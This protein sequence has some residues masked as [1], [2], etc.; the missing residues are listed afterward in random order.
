MLGHI[1]MG[2]R[3][4]H[5]TNQFLAFNKPPGIA[6]QSR[7]D[8]DFYQLANGYA[9]RKLYVVHRIDQPASGIVLFARSKTSAGLISAGFAESKFRRVYH[10]V[11]SRKPNVTEGTIHHWL[12]HN[13][14]TNKSEIA[15][16]PKVG[17]KPCKLRFQF[18][19]SSD[20]WH[21]LK[22][23]IQTGRH[24][25]IRAQLSAEGMHIKGDVKYGARRPNRDRSIH[26]HASE[27]DMI[28]PVN[29][30]RVTI[31]ASWPNE[32]LWNF[33]KGSLDSS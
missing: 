33:F 6:V 10:T 22:V 4:C 17:F 21:L 13:P 28:H 31:K 7:E 15:Q 12:K 26:L 11:V 30:D 19:G 9:K 25:Q 5:K 1:N 24:H 27:I 14:K 8:V 32:V 20:H 16:N 23:E 2:D 29:G 3:L 18:L